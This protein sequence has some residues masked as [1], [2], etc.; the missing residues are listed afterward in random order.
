MIKTP[1]QLLI[2]VMCLKNI[3]ELLDVLN[4]KQKT[5]ICMRYELS[6]YIRSHTFKEIGDHLSVTTERIRQIECRA[7]MKM[8]S[9][10]FR[11]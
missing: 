5:V 8:R 6:P 9:Y 2:D 3:D 7:V 1:T 4:P 10:L 11:K